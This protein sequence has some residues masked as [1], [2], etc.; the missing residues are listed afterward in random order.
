MK[1]MIRPTPYPVLRQMV[2]QLSRSSV[3]LECVVPGLEGNCWVRLSAVEQG[4]LT[5]YGT[6]QIGS[7]S[8]AAP[9]SNPRRRQ[10]H[11]NATNPPD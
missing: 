10:R 8:R 7:Y 2:T 6:V 4:Y 5:K 11:E 9:S 1:W 3:E